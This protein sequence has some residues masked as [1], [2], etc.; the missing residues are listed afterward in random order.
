M[1]R[2]AT[3]AATVDYAL[4]C[5]PCLLKDQ[6][7]IWRGEYDNPKTWEYLWTT[8]RTAVGVAPGGLVFLVVADGEGV[9]GGNGASSYQLGVFFRDVLGATT[10]MNFDG[11]LSTL[12][13]LR[14]ASGPRMV[15]TITGEDS[16][17]DV[18]PYVKVLQDKDGG[19]G[20]VFSYLRAG[21]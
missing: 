6:G 9:N 12:M 13:V 8:A 10:A 5:A 19:P 2:R 1:S 7:V 21:S 15:N 17:W 11:G 18:D 16:S 14:G 20:G 4:Q 3:G